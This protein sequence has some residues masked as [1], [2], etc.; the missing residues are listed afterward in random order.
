MDSYWPSRLLSAQVP[1]CL[2]FPQKLTLTLA[3]LFVAWLDRTTGESAAAVSPQLSERSA[4]VA[5]GGS[6][7]S[8][9][10]LGDLE[11]DVSVV[12]FTGEPSRRVRWRKSL[13]NYFEKIFFFLFFF[14]FFLFVLFLW[15]LIHPRFG[16][17][18]TSWLHC[19]LWVGGA[20][21]RSS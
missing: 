15:T 21:L 7:G 16:S 6:D 8:S 20:G 14:V 9:L 10:A 3:L 18:K 4:N 11:V 1:H 19:V 2:F 17:R 13:N 5:L 12:S